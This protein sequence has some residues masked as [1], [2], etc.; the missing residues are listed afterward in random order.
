MFG[1][2]I[3]VGGGG[4]D[5][6]RGGSDS[7]T[8]FLFGTSFAGPGRAAISWGRLVDLRRP[9]ASEQPLEKWRPAEYDPDDRGQNEG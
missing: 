9:E 1:F 6:H 7:I 2:L 5:G 3:V 4:G 8:T